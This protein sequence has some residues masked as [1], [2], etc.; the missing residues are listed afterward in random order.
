MNAAVGQ[1]CPAYRILEIAAFIPT[2][3]PGL[4]KI[5]VN[6]SDQKTGV[7]QYKLEST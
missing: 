6:N 5:F 3:R 2:H 4:L 1:E 7:L